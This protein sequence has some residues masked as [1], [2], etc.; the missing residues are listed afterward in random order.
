MI[1][2]PVLIKIVARFVPNHNPVLLTFVGLRR[3]HYLLGRR[4][5]TLITVL[6]LWSLSSGEVLVESN[7]MGDSIF[8]CIF[9]LQGAPWWRRR[10]LQ[11]E[12]F[13]L[14]FGLAD[15]F[16]Y[17]TLL[18][19][20]LMVP[21]TYFSSFIYICASLGPFRYQGFKSFETQMLMWIYQVQIVNTLPTVYIVASELKDPIWHSSEWQIGSFSSEATIYRPTCQHF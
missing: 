7:Y 20:I 6:L 11:S 12:A 3:K 19:W 8:D 21:R 5:Y 16:Q 10:L 13:P 17:Y 14:H 4:L 1:N 18:S 9:M 2:L 15:H